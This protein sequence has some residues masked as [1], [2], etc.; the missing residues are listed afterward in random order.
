MNER[1]E[2]DVVLENFHIEDIAFINDA[3]DISLKFF[4]PDGLEKELVFEDV[5]FFSCE[6]I[7]GES[8]GFSII[9][10]TLKKVDDGTQLMKEV[11]GVG[12]SSQIGPVIYLSIHGCLNV[13]L[14]SSDY[15]I[16]D[17]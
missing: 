3:K 10:S 14:V 2:L 17:H 11:S 12:Y 7:A 1:I 13:K 6:K 5:L 9:D 4:I 16:N 8:A 15:R